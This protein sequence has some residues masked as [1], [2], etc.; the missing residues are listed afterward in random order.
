MEGKEIPKSQEKLVAELKAKMYAFLKSNF[1]EFMNWKDECIR[2]VQENYPDPVL[3]QEY[4]LWHVLIGGT[5]YRKCPHFDFAGD[6]SIQKMIEK[7]P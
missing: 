4:K 2:V 1:P 6:S 3:R 5:G 7:L